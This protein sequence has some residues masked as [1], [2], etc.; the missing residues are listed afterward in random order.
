MCNRAYSNIT[1]IASSVVSDKEVIPAISSCVEEVPELLNWIEE[2]DRR[3]VVHVEWVVRVKQCQ[4]VVVVS[5]DTDNLAL[6]LH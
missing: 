5:Y 3:L 1:I 4:R 6:L 2:T